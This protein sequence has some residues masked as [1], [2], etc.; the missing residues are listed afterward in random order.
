MKKRNLSFACVVSLISLLMVLAP[1]C[2]GKAEDANF[3]I[4][5]PGFLGMS[6]PADFRAFDPVS[7]WNTKIAPNP[8]IDPYSK[9]IIARL[10][11]TCPTLTGSFILWTVPLFVINA[12]NSPKVTVFIKGNNVN[13]ILDPN[14]TR[15]VTGVPIPEGVWPDPAEDGH[16][17]LVDPLLM[18][19]WSFTQAKRL[20]SNTWSVYGINT[21]D[22]TGLGYRSPDS[23]RLSHSDGSRGSGFPLI[24][25]LI[26]PEEIEAGI[27]RHAL[28]FASP[29]NRKTVLCAPPASTTDGWREGIE[30]IPEGTRLQLD[31]N[32]DLDSLN[33][34]YAA[35]IIARALQEYGMFCG[36]NSEVLKLYF[37]N[38]GEKGNVWVKKYDY[39]PDLKK[40]PLC[41]FRVLKCNQFPSR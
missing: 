12:A 35:K 13:P 38:L 15:V 19:S 7:P 40:I 22:L 16:M 29:V 18:R 26:R 27:I 4:T 23:G 11:H 37:Q 33:L 36:D 20:S 6:L 1:A 8:P 24:A 9:L 25:G 28:V 31:P 34:S 3:R 10:K 21:W 5:G 39:I 32:L 14:E 41:R 2:S 30:F 17:L